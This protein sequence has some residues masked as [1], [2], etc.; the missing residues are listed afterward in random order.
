MNWRG[1]QL[2][3]NSFLSGRLGPSVYYMDA[4]SFEWPPY[5]I[6]FPL[7]KLLGKCTHF[8]VIILPGN[9]YCDYK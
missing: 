4:Y 9:L 5:N 2:T 7:S 6:T 8:V 3:S 1:E